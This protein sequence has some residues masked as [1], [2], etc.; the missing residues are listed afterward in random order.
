M[1][2]SEAHGHKVVSTGDAST[3]GVVDAF[4]L[5]PAAGTI[6]GL[7][8][9][10]T[11][12]NGSLLPWSD[13]TAFGVDAVT[14]AD[15]HLIVEPQGEL[16]ELGGKAHHFLKKRVLTTAGVQVGTV[17]DI[18]FDPATGK[19]VSIVTD[20]QPIDGSSL[21]GIGSYAVMVRS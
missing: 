19:I 14:I 16:A 4:V 8:L 17:R 11:A 10:K 15:T 12:G 9:K 1:L 13:I 18:D 3:A 5:D 21:I 6:A 7:S 20:A 2:I